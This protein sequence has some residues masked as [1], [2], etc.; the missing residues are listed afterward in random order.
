MIFGPRFLYLF[1]FL[2]HLRSL[3][4]SSLFKFYFL[5][6]GNFPL[7]KHL[8]KASF[9]LSWFVL[10]LWKVWSRNVAEETYLLLSF[11]SHDILINSHLITYLH[12]F[13]RPSFLHNGSE[14]T[15]TFRRLSNGSGNLICSFKVSKH[16]GFF[17]LVYIKLI[18][19][20]NSISG[21]K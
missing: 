9:I 5:F 21:C 19:L 14:R 2:E 16:V 11:N 17:I 7:M 6:F 1:L 15:T 10:L 20:I 13:T 4:L 3:L 8:F 18:N 12:F